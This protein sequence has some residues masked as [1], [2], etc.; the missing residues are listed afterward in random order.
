MAKAGILG[1]GCCFFVAVPE[2]Y[3]VANSG[4]EAGGVEGK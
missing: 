4:G 3:L 1:E 2:E